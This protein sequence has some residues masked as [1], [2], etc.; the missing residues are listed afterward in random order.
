MFTVLYNGTWNLNYSIVYY[1][2]ADP[3]NAIYFYRYGVC[4]LTPEVHT[5]NLGS[6]YNH[7]GINISQCITYMSYVHFMYI[8]R[9]QSY[10]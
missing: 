9:E 5:S 10:T 2:Y 8:D 4:L 7:A 6:I 3:Y 1:Q